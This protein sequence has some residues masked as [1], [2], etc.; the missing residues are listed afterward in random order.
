MKQ[1]LSVS[2]FSRSIEN[3][4]PREVSYLSENQDGY[5]AGEPLHADLRFSDVRVS[6]GQRYIWLVCGDGAGSIRLDLVKYIEADDED[7]SVLGTRYRVCCGVY[8]KEEERI[9]TLIA[10][11]DDS[12]AA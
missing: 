10:L 6:V 12:P 9:F 5:D 4:P 1:R 8:G 7:A 3:T 2:E 11:K